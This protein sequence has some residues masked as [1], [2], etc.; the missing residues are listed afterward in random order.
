MLTVALLGVKRPAE[1]G[2]L[3]HQSQADASAAIYRTPSLPAG[4][5]L[6]G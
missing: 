3:L 4:Q 6:I 1:V 2:D 5:D